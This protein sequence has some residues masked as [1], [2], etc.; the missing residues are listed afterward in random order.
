MKR[1]ECI[2]NEVR[3]LCPHEEISGKICSACKLPD[4][5]RVKGKVPESNVKSCIDQKG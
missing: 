1:Y 4:L 3:N 2:I 5:Y